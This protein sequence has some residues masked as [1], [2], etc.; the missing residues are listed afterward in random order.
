MTASDSK[1]T[2]RLPEEEQ[3]DRFTAGTPYDDAFRTM[4]ND[5]PDLLI[6]VINEIFGTNYS[7]D[8]KVLFGQNEHFINTIEGELEKRITDSSFR[9]VERAGKTSGK[10]LIECQSK[11]D[12][13]MVVRIFEYATQIALDEN[14]IV[15]NRMTVEIPCAAILFLRN[16]NN[17][18]DKLEIEIVTPGGTVLFDIPSMKLASYNI[19]NI[20]EKELYFLIP[21]FLFNREKIFADC[22]TDEVKLKDLLEEIS[23]L[24]RRL[25]HAMEEDHLSAYQRC[26]ILDMAKLVSDG[27]TEKYGRVRKGVETIMRG[28]IIETEASRIYREGAKEADRN[29][30]I[31]V[32]K[33]MLDDGLEPERVARILNITVEKLEE[34]VGLLTT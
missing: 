12:S 22:E 23:G 19:G 7:I 5:C 20:F 21:F 34:L 26:I 3:K 32:A 6:P 14:V 10:Y 8:A 2:E 9:I 28:R 1:K 4:T 33:A 18:P 15:G 29:R 25:D 17:T 30:L 27:L 16:N 24:I 13:T 11:P 31:Q